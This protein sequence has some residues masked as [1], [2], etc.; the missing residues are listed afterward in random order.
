MTQIRPLLEALVVLNEQGIVHR[1]LKPENLLIHKGRVMIADFGLSIQ[2][3]SGYP[4]SAHSSLHQSE[5]EDNGGKRSASSCPGQGGALSSFPTSIATNASAAGSPLY[6]A[7]E[8]LRTMFE[9]KPM[10]LALSPKND[11]W[12]LG[13][14]VL[15]AILGYHPMTRLPHDSSLA[16]SSCSHYSHAYS[17]GQANMLYN[18]AYLKQVPLPDSSHLLG[19]QLRAFLSLALKTDPEQRPTAEELLSSLNKWA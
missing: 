18:I 4:P 8:V 5:E 2:S 13:I 9:N 7:P 17:G 19:G 16:P 14:M 1:D 12:A 3:Q 15:E 10:T 6:A 11:V